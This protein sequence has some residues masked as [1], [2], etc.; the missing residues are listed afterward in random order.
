MKISVDKISKPNP[1]QSYVVEY[2]ILND[3]ESV[4]VTNREIRV[5]LGQSAKSQLEAKLAEYEAT[6]AAVDVEIG[7]I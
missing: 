1:D 7:I 4:E 3:D 2:S 6:I 5:E